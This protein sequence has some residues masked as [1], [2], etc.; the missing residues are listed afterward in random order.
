MI[1][2]Q[3]SLSVRFLYT[4]F[5]ILCN[6]VSR[7]TQHSHFI[8][9]K[10]K[11][12]KQK[13]DLKMLNSLLPTNQHTPTECQWARI[14]AKKANAPTRWEIIRQVLQGGKCRN[15]QWKLKA[16]K[17]KPPHIISKAIVLSVNVILFLNCRFFPTIVVVSRNSQKIIAGAKF[18]YANTMLYKTTF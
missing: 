15:M 7:S 18:T 11:K 8:S 2:L 6:G 14:T 17:M 1:A 5:S 16:F 3:F 4:Y 10:E 13:L 9:K 12:Q